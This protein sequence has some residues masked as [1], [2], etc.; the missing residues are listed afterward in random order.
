MAY[1]TPD[2]INGAFEFVGAIMNFSN[3]IRLY[4]DKQVKGV[5]IF[6]SVFFSLWGIWNLY[7]YPHLDQW[8]SFAGGCAIVIVNLIW[9]GGALYYTRKNRRK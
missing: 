4:E 7:Y 9:V 6:P 1:T 5:N 8:L 3:V 2:A